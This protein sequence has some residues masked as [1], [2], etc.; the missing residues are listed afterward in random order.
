M[1]LFFATT[2]NDAEKKMVGYVT[3]LNFRYMNLCIKSEPA[4]LLPVNVLFG[5]EEQNIEELSQIGVPDEFHLAVIPTVD[6]A[7]PYI[8]KGVAS[9]H[10]E[11]KL[12][13][14]TME[15]NGEEKKYLLYEMPEVDKNRRDLLNGAIKSLHDEAK[16][17]IDEVK[18]KTK[19]SCGDLLKGS[20]QDLDEVNKAIDTAHENYIGKINDLLVEKE[21]EIE[22]GYQRYLKEHDEVDIPET[23][24]HDVVFGMRMNQSDE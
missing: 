6:D 13:M 16:V 1:N 15:I 5:T 19:L 17:R 21:L 3:L 8:V 20:P 14:K 7:I 12:E 2:V 4:S 22:Q 11:F 9:A 24:D 10:P 18:V 23:N